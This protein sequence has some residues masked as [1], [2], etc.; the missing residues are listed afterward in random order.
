MCCDFPVLLPRYV[1]LKQCR[2]WTGWQIVLDLE[3]KSRGEGSYLDNPRQRILQSGSHQ[4]Q[5]LSC[6]LNCHMFNLC[7]EV[8]TMRGSNS[9]KCERYH[10][11]QLSTKFYKFFWCWESCLCSEKKFAKSC[12]KKSSNLLFCLFFEGWILINV[13][14]AL[15]IFSTM[16]FEPDFFANV[17]TFEANMLGQRPWEAM[18]WLSCHS[19]FIER[20]NRSKER[21]RGMRKSVG[22]IVHHR[23][24]RLLL[25]P[26]LGE[27]DWAEPAWARKHFSVVRVY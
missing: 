3:S 22:E 10:P 18:W 20:N 6:I 2:S 27:T 12:Q 25:L 5:G 24:G 11:Q 17:S 4:G 23:L 15:Y 7:K 21:R 8:W 13:A 1:I 19:A 9:M 26:Y 16:V 14:C